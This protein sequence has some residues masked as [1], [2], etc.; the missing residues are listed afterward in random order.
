MAISGNFAQLEGELATW[1]SANYALTGQIVIGQFMS[2]SEKDYDS[3]VTQPLDTNPEIKRLR[4]CEMYATNVRDNRDTAPTKTTLRTHTF[5]LDARI[6]LV[7][8]DSYR[9]IRQMTQWLMDRINQGYRIDVGNNSALIDTVT[10][11]DSAIRIDDYHGDLVVY[12]SE[13]TFEVTERVT[14]D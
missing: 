6:Q 7:D 9:D 14:Y 8:R 3:I 5:Q 2:D 11:A 12:L 4:F 10:S 13:I 1:L